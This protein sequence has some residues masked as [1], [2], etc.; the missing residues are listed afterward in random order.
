MAVEDMAG[1]LHQCVARRSIGQPVCGDR[2]IWQPTDPGQGI[3]TA[4]VP[5]DNVLSRPDHS[6]RDK[7]LAANLTLMAVV[8]APTP[9]PSG[10]LLDQYLVAAELIGV[11]A[12]VVAA[13]MDLLDHAARETFLD[14]LAPYPPLGYPLCPVSTKGTPGLGALTGHLTRQTAILLGQSGVGKSSLVQ[15][16]LPDQDIQVGRLSRATGLG[17]HTTSAATCYQLSSEPDAGR[18]IDSPGVRSF[19]LSG[20]DQSQLEAGF[21]EL[22]PLR[23]RCRFRDCRHLQEPDCAVRAAVS[24]GHIDP[25]RLERFHQLREGLPG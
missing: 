4:L 22:R 11:R 14:A 17:R 16:L 7:P 18:L 24:G 3:I 6:G 2:V 13:K 1:G 23:G 19:R 8:V 5:R 9:P 21:P 10:Y 25:R 15:A 12:L 20:V